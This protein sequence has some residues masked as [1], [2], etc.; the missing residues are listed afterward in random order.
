V[1]QAGPASAE[2]RSETSEA[3]AS[4]SR[5]GRAPADLPEASA[6]G[7]EASAESPETPVSDLAQASAAGAAAPDPVG[8]DGGG[9]DDYLDGAG[10]RARRWNRPPSLRWPSSVPE[11][12]VPENPAETGAGALPRGRTATEPG[13]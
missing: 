11:A 1:G 3:T 13:V 10:G 8:E 7:G 4:L 2:S 6:A 5:A 9:L 12:P